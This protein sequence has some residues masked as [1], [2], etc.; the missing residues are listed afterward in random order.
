M[1]FIGWEIASLNLL[2]IL[3]GIVAY[4]QQ[5][6]TPKPVA[7]TPEQAQQQKMAMFMSTALLPIFDVIAGS[8]HRGCGMPPTGL[9]T[10]P[11]SFGEVAA[12]PLLTSGWWRNWRR[13]PA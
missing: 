2:P 10:H 4:L 12:W 7:A 11:R 9:E 13:T 8:Y 3:M 1:P 6:Y 5:K